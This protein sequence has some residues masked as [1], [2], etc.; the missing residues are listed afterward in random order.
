M[1]IM[2]FMHCCISVKML[3]YKLL[4][5][6]SILRI[7]KNLRLHYC[8]RKFFCVM[9]LMSIFIIIELQISLFRYNL[10]FANLLVTDINRIN[11]AA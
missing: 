5:F 2:S 8:R 7:N 4:H 6:I 10:T 3:I 11:I 1:D 9:V